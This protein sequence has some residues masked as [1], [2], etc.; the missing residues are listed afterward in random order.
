M[1]YNSKLDQLLVSTVQSGFGENF[2]ANN[3]YFYDPITAAV[4][5][6]VSYDGYYFPSVIVNH[7]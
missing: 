1:S 3:L 7:K 5:K 2:K 6:T 4:K